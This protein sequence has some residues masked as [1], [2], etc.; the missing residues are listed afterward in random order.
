MFSSRKTLYPGRYYDSAFLK[1][2][3]RCL[4]QSGYSD[5]HILLPNNMKLE[6]TEL[7]IDEFIEKDRNYRSQ[8]IVAKNN[9]N[10]DILKI[11]IVNISEKS[12]FNDDT[13]PSGHSEPSE[14]YV[15]SNDPLRANATVSFFYEYFKENGKTN[16]CSVPIVNIMLGLSL[17]IVFLMSPIISKKIDTKLFQGKIPLIVFQIISYLFYALFITMFILWFIRISGHGIYIKKKPKHTS[18]RIWMNRAIHGEFI[19]NPLVVSLSVLISGIVIGLFS[20]LV[21]RFL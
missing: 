16:I 1:D 17:V 12:F 20:G 8:I 3:A 15:K 19:D 10:G 2:F 6:S 18:L 13:F 14:I 4:Q 9:E 11:L 21:I 5:I 7:S